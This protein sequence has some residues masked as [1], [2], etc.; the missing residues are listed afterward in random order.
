MSSSLG[1]PRSVEVGAFRGW[2]RGRVIDLPPR[3]LE[4]PIA[5]L[6]GPQ[7]R[8]LRAKKNTVVEVPGEPGWIVRRYAPR[9]LHSL[10]RNSVMVSKEANAFTFALEY[11]RREIPTAPVLAFLE[12]HESGLFRESILVTKK[13]PST[14]LKDRVLAADAAEKGSRN[15]GKGRRA[16]LRAFARFVRRAHAAG[17]YHGDL[18]GANVLVPDEVTAPAEDA[19]VLIDVNRTHFGEPNEPKSVAAD[20]AH[21]GGTPDE[22][23]FVLRC[24]ADSGAEYLRLRDKV[25]RL[26]SMK[27]TRKRL[28]RALGLKKTL[29]SLKLR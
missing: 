21:I 11:E 26:R 8:V 29:T 23:R 14:T 24:Y 28:N 15:L 18:N 17:V 22:R 4:D 19:F 25:L 20:L 27:D 6:Q 13:V 2:V 1:A 10:V 3:F 12:R 5:A 16:W 7:V 9:G